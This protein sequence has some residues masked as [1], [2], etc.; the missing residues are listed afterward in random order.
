MPLL[1]CAFCGG[2]AIHSLNCL[3]C[4]GETQRHALN[5]LAAVVPDWLRAQ[6]PAEWYEHNGQRFENYR[7]PVGKPERYALAET[8]GADGFQLLRW[9]TPARVRKIPAAEVLR[10]VRLQQFYASEETLRWCV[11]EDLAPSSLMICTPYDVEAR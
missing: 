6:V 9:A 7:L 8:I 4:V 1:S 10:Q 3:E 11:A 2:P 5:V